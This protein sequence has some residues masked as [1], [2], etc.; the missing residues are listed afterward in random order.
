MGPR[1]AEDPAAGPAPGQV[2]RP[3]G[4]WAHGG[5][6]RGHQPPG[7]NGH[8]LASLLKNHEIHIPPET[9]A[10]IGHKVWAASYANKIKW[11]QITKRVFY[12]NRVIIFQ[13]NDRNLPEK[14]PDIWKP[15][16]KTLNKSRV[17]KE[18]K[19]KVESF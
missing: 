11:I 14:A 7:H 5:L 3:L 2:A 9:F 19:G 4:Q 15:S 12:E 16:K 8:L 1:A 17:Q 18:Q 6:E 10:K 13:S